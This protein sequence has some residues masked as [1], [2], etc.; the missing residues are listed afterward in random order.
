M[1]KT[2]FL[3][4]A[5]V[6]VGSN[7]F[8]QTTVDLTLN[9]ARNVATQALFADDPERALLIAE[10]ILSK[11]PDDR[12]SLMIIATAAPRVGDPQRGR[13]AGARAWAVST[14]DTQKYEAARVTA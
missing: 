9:Q 12:I 2:Y 5:L 3:I 7:S 8:A 1:I 14:T 13:R 6:V 11:L 4:A 10:T